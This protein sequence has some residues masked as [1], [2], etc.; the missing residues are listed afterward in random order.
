MVGAMVGA[1]V[2][3]LV[4]WSL[5]SRSSVAHVAVCRRSDR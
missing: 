4:G 5:A 2:G 1:M 3:V